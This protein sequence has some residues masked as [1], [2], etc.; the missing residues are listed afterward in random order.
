VLRLEKILPIQRRIY[1]T[2]PFLLK[3]FLKTSLGNVSYKHTDC[4]YSAEQ[5]KTMKTNRNYLVGIFSLSLLSTVALADPG[6]GGGASGK[7][8]MYFDTNHD[9]TVTI[10]ELNAAVKQRFGKM[11]ADSNGE[12]TM[13]EFQ[14]YIQQRR[15]EHQQQRFADMDANKD[16]NLSKEE[17][18]QYRQKR[19]EQRFQQLDGNND[20]VVSQE[21]YQAHKRDFRGGKHGHHGKHGY[22]KYG[23]HGKHG[24]C[25]HR[26]G[27]RFFARM[28]SNNDGQLT[29][30]ESLAAWTKWFNRL[31]TNHDQ[32]VTVDELKAFRDTMKRR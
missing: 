20:G 15:A 11:D 31:D 19:L 28:D 2:R 16:G 7:F 32:V 30:D 18:I 8:M 5:V 4:Q 21:E 29:L 22:G 27:G 1:S 25:D 17:Y 10:D 14:A 13:D 3:R 6:H 23:H 26:G 12:V 9:N 24:A